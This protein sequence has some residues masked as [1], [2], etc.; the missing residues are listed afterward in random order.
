MFS[1]TAQADQLCLCGAVA[2]EWLSVGEG[3]QLEVAGFFADQ[4]A[5]LE[6]EIQAGV[7][8]GSVRADV[9]PAQ[10]ARLIFASLEGSMLM[11]RAGS[12]SDLAAHFGRLLFS[13][14]E[15]A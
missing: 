7:E 14:V 15:A 3:P 6:A 5:W 10:V 2:A 9:D 13:M 1:R 8:A 12:E 4:V 11:T